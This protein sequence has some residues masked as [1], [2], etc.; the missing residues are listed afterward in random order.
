MEDSIVCVD[1]CHILN[2]LPPVQIY[3]ESP[4]QLFLVFRLNKTSF[5]DFILSDY[6]IQLKINLFGKMIKD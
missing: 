4:T 5:L 3:L 6:P 2:W 1:L